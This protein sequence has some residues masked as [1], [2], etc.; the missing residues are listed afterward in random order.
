MKLSQDFVKQ[1]MEN[2]KRKKENKKVIPLPFEEGMFG[3]CKYSSYFV[4][5]DLTGIGMEPELEA[6]FDICHHC[7][8]YFFEHQEKQRL[9]DKD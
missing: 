2:L 4:E 8:I 7:Q 6:H 9:Y 3:G 1:V 5:S